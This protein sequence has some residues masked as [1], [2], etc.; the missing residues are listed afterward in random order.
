VSGEAI[1]AEIQSFKSP[2]VIR[3]CTIEGRGPSSGT[4]FGIRYDKPSSSQDVLEVIASR[5]IAVNEATNGGDTIALFRDPGSVRAVGSTFEARTTNAPAYGIKG[6][7]YEDVRFEFTGCVFLTACDDERQS[8]VFDIWS[9]VTTGDKDVFVRGCDFSKWYGVIQALGPVRTQ[10]ERIL[11]VS[12]ASDTAIH[13]GIQLSGSEQEVTTG[14]TNPD[15][16][17]AL[18]VVGV[19]TWTSSADV[20][21]VGANLAGQPITDKITLPSG[22][23][24]SAEGKKPFRTV[25]KI[26]VPAAEQGHLQTIRV[27]TTNKL[28]LS[29]PLS[30]TSDVLQ[31]AKISGSTWQIQTSALTVDVNH[32]TVKPSSISNGDS[33]EF[34]Y[35]TAG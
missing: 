1:G 25:T 23:N 10:V 17:R 29:S 27:G 20:W 34:T 9:E 28:G 33:F 13:S 12:A 26:I 18:K 5:V 3:N 14:I 7:N 21:I 35:L 4:V 19:G 30:A 8:E 6:G 11:S 24:P 22:S 16:Y 31:W 2:F 32:A 15:A